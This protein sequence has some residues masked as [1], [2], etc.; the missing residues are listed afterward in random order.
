M[1][2]DGL[3]GISAPPRISHVFSV[4]L[5]L[6]SIHRHRVLSTEP[7]P[8]TIKKCWLPLRMRLVPTARLYWKLGSPEEPLRQR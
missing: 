8:T 6:I 1:L 4:L 2:G 5:G 3:D 7:D